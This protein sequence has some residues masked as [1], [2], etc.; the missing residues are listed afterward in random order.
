MGG[1]GSWG[2]GSRNGSDGSSWRKDQNSGEIKNVKAREELEVTSPMKVVN[3]SP[4]QGG[5]KKALFL[6]P[7]KGEVKEVVRDELAGK[8]V[9]VNSAM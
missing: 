7:A 6:G 4:G 5:A 8:S 2:S 1:S 3:D 9:D